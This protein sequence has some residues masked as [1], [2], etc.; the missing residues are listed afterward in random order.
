[1]DIQGIF[2]DIKYFVIDHHK[3]ILAVLLPILAIILYITL[4]T[5]KTTGSVSESS[6]YAGLDIEEQLNLYDEKSMLVKDYFSVHSEVNHGISDNAVGMVVDLHLK[7]PYTEEYDMQE[8]LKDLTELYKFKYNE[9][10]NQFLAGIKYN[11][12]LRELDFLEDN[13][14][15]YTAVYQMSSYTKETEKEIKKNEADGLIGQ[16]D[17]KWEQTLKQTKLPD[18]TKYSLTIDY[19]PLVNNIT[20]LS[21]EE[22]VFYNKLM[23]Y[24]ALAGSFTGGVK[25]YTLWE[26]GYNLNVDREWL[27]VKQFED[28]VKRGRDIYSFPK[29]NPYEDNI[30]LFEET[31]VKSN[32]VLYVY[33]KYGELKDSPLE[34]KRELIKINYD[35]Y[36]DIILSDYEDKLDS[37]EEGNEEIEEIKDLLEVVGDT[38]E[39]EEGTT[40]KTDE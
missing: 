25:L 37:D 36:Y 32:P 38:D 2:L 10:K 15:D 20:P 9:N 18:Y 31:M 23:K 35:K 4:T 5:E 13:P 29:D 27:V 1:M 39:N 34:A 17:Y 3:K 26:H 22:Y 24:E 21:N 8:L 6:V 19:E 12:Y 16:I 40:D 7:R 30:Y 14:P 11:I 28:F 33:A